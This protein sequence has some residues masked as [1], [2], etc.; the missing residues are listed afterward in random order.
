VGARRR[1]RVGGAAHA[2]ASAQ[3]GQ[4]ETDL[5]EHRGKQGVLLEAVAA[6]ARAHQLGEDRLHVQAHRPAQ[7]DV[8]VLEGDGE[9]V[10]Q[11]ERAQGGEVRARLA[12]ETDAFEV[13]GKIERH[14]RR[15]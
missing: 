7:L 2:H 6:A 1:R 4:A 8:E 15:V 11:V 14:G 12:A 5:L 9:R 3:A 10:R 13:P